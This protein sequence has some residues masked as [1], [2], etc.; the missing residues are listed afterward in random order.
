MCIPKQTV[1]QGQNRAGDP[2]A[3]DA[4]WVLE[5]LGSWRLW[6]LFQAIN[7]QSRGSNVFGESDF[8]SA[9]GLP[10]VAIALV[11][12]MG[13]C[14][15]IPVWPYTSHDSWTQQKTASLSNSFGDRFEPLLVSCAC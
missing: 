14:F 12:K 6:V 15:S 11:A 1:S 8:S 9:R 5:N 7:T 13:F 4:W 10:A 3:A 2:E